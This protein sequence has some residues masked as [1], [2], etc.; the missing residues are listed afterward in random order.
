MPESENCSRYLGKIP[1]IGPVEV[2]V[3]DNTLSHSMDGIEEF[4]VFSTVLVANFY[5]MSFA[6][7]VG[8][9]WS[10]DGHFGWCMSG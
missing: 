1:K 7:A 6:F 8:A 3:G 5:V 2:V 9:C 4:V 10:G